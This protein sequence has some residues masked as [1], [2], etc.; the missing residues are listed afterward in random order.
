M[1]MSELLT[2]MK[3]S[4]VP[5][6]GTVTGRLF[7]NINTPPWDAVYR[8]AAGW[9]SVE[10]SPWPFFRRFADWSLVAA[11]L[12]VL[13]M[14]R[15][16]P[17]VARRVLPFA[18][19]TKAVWAE[20]RQLGKR[21]DSYQWRKL[22]WIGVGVAACSIWSNRLSVAIISVATICM[23]VGALGYA[24]WRNISKRPPYSRALAKVETR[25]DKAAGTP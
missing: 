20:H 1:G 24:T 9:V 23:V 4:E 13:V 15:V 22:F 16:V 14:V 6:P 10:I 8:F 21:F 7:V 18:K 2:G 12:V 5:K 25:M 19:S 11:L 17:G 3:H